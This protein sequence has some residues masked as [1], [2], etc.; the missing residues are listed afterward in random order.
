MIAFFC[1]TNDYSHKLGTES[2]KISYNWYV[3][4]IGN[5]DFTKVGKLEDQNQIAEIGVVMDVESIVN[6]MKY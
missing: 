4:K 2:V 6:R 5:E 3:W 1:L